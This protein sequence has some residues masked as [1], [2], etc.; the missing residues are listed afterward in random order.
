MT[1]TNASKTAATGIVVSNRIPAGAVFASASASQGTVSAPAVGSNG[2]VTVNV[3]SLAG[4]A[5]AT[6]TVLVT[7]AD[8]VLRSCDHGRHRV[9]SA[10]ADE[11]VGPSGV[12]GQPATVRG[13]GHPSG[14]GRRSNPRGDL[15]LGRGGAPSPSRSGWP[16]DGWKVL[17][18]PRSVSDA[19]VASE[20]RALQ[21]SGRTRAAS[22]GTN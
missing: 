8:G 6:I 14:Q 21:D 18:P 7:A 19:W 11:G 16:S 13:R 9:L 10:V 4:R 22:I 15:R 3:G 5:T 2:T 17:S 1:V 12:F 20:H